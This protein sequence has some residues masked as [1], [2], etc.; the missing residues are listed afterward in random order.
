[1]LRILGLVPSAK[2]WVRFVT[3]LQKVKME[4]GL[5]EQKTPQEKKDE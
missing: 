3:E 4:E 1:M 5:N 2:Q